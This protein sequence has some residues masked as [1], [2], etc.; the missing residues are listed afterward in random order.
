MAKSIPI[1]DSKKLHSNFYSQK[2]NRRIANSELRAIHALD[3]ETRN[4]D[5]FLIA[6]SDGNYLDDINTKSVIKFLF[7]RKYENSWNFFYNLTYD[8]EVILKLL[9]AELIRYKKNGKLNFQY[10]GFKIKYIPDKCLTIS[11]GHHSV[12]FYDI[13]QFYKSSLAVAYE[14]NIGEIP[15]QYKSMKNKR[16]QFSKSFYRDNRKMV[17][18]YCIQDCKYT[19]KLSEHFVR[20]FFDVFGFYPQRWISSGYLAEKVLI[21]NEI[22]IPKIED[23]AQEIH[24][25][26]YRCYYGGR[27]EM[28]KRGFIGNAFIYDINSAYPYA[29]TKIP[30]LRNGRWIKTRSIH[31]D[32]EI[33]FFKIQADVSDKKIICPFPFR[34]YDIFF[35]SGKFVTY[36]TLHELQSCEKGDSYKI[37]ESFQFIPDSKS[38]P[39][40]KFIKELYKKRQILKKE[41]SPM[42][43]PIK[44]IINSIYGKF[45]QKKRGKIGSLFN[46]ILFSFITGYT[47]AMLYR[48]VCKNNLENDTVAFATD[49][50]CTTRKININSDRLGEFSLDTKGDDCYFLQNGFYRINEKWK[51]RGFGSLKGREIEHLETF[52]KDEKLFYK[53]EIKRSGRLRSNIISGKIEDIGKIKVHTRQINLNADR[54][55]LWLGELD[56]IN[57]KHNESMPLSFNYFA[58]DEI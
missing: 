16:T 10:N 26:A 21:N 48:F 54:K 22:D 32:A 50:I 38:Y 35:P 56:G 24:E 31:K 7:R 58:K 37:L 49:S 8:A 2:Q 17:R 13:A 1:T 5:I 55:R 40:S 53:F 47:R 34:K 36:C 30:D 12:I 57:R 6:D 23:F 46:P 52:E 27:F 29:I 25:F 28:I 20:I 45:G 19:K 41:N 11:K 4:G 14:K 39:Y 3:T 9:G 51:Q 15:N 43:L 42:Q 18:D 33:G 44:I